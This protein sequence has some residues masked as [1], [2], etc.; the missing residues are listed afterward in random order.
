MRIVV[1]AIGQTIKVILS[2]KLHII[3]FLMY[4]EHSISNFPITDIMSAVYVGMRFE[5]I[6]RC[7]LAHWAIAA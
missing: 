2:R 3:S 4:I 6:N 7:N 1:D 5:G